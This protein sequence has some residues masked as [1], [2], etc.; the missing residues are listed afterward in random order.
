LPPEDKLTVVSIAGR[1]GRQE[2]YR[3]DAPEPKNRDVLET[4]LKL[5]KCAVT[6]PIVLVGRLRN[7]CLRTLAAC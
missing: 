3:D 1:I 5:E 6:A 2:L 7:T 4:M